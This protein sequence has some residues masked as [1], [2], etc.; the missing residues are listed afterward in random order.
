LNVIF[1]AANLTFGAGIVN[2]AFAIR[3]SSASFLGVNSGEIFSVIA[4]RAEAGWGVDVEEILVGPRLV[5]L[6]RL[7]AIE[8]RY[9][10]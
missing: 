2:E 7:A 4:R 6:P 8:R 5:P 10:I 3:C 1:T 9:Y